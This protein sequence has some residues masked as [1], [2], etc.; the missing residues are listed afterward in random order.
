VD[1]RQQ[2]RGLGEFLLIDA[3]RR[4]SI[5]A[6]HVAAHAVG[7]RR[8]RRRRKEILRVRYGFLEL[9]DNPRHL[10]LPMVSV[11]RIIA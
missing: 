2:R 3:L 7:P 5:A 1:V 6:K 4:V 11:R 8:G 10:Y 9:T